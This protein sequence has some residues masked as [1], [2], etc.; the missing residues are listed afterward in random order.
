MSGHTSHVLPTADDW[1]AIHKKAFTDPV[2]HNKLE[3]DPTAAINEYAA[4]KNKTFTKLVDT[5]GWIDKS[6]PYVE[7]R[8]PPVACC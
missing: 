6:K 5:R 3:T 8:K 4:E 7:T 2:F 1:A